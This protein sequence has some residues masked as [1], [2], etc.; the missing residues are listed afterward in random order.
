MYIYVEDT[1]GNI[2]EYKFKVI[3]VGLILDK[4]IIF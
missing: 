3:H 1:T 2:S 4:L